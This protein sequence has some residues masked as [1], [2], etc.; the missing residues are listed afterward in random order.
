MVRALA[1]KMDEGLLEDS[2]V[3][4]VEADIVEEKDNE[5]GRVA[6]IVVDVGAG[7]TVDAR[8]SNVSEFGSIT[9]VVMICG[10]RGCS[11]GI[12]GI[13]KLITG[14]SVTCLK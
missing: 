3:E 9:Y 8:A 7:N 12:G 6:V 4:F 10:G 14:P 13:G 1:L 2:I 11:G 5:V